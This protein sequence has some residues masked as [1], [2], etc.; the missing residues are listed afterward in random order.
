VRNP[1]ATS[2]ARAAC[3]RGRATGIVALTG[4][5]ADRLREAELTYREVGSTAGEFPPGYRH[6]RRSAVIGSGAAA[7]NRASDALRALAT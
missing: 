5:A 2:G 7:F 3:W 6:L 1:R 4:K